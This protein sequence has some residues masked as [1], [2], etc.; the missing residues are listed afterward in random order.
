[1][2]SLI[3]GLIINYAVFFALIHFIVTRKPE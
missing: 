2:S 1:M 3:I